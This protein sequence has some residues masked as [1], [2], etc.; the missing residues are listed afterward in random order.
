M[1]VAEAKNLY[2]AIGY[3][4]SKW[5]FIESH[6][7]LTTNTLYKNASLGDRPA[8]IPKFAEHQ[9]RFILRCLYDCSELRPVKSEGESL[10]NESKKQKDMREHF[11][12]SAL[13]ADPVRDQVYAF[14]RFDAQEIEHYVNDWEFDLKTFPDLELNLHRIST[15]WSEFSEKVARIY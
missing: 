15:E 4:V 7:S 8:R 10:I 13:R 11:V 14:T 3:I 12:H 6:C 2:T 9:Y 5:G 1:K